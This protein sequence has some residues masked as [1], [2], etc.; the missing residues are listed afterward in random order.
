MQEIIVERPYR[1]VPPHRGDW[2][3]C[4]MQ[5]FRV[6]DRYLRKY[7]GIHSY[8]VRGIDYLKESLRQKAGIIL[9]PNHCR[10]ADPL[11]MC[12]V[13]RP[14]D[15]SPYAMASWHLFQRPLQTLAIRLCG[16]FSVNREGVDRQALET[17]ISAIAEGKRPLI[18]F[19]EGTVFRSNDVLQPLLD[20]IAFIARSA[21]K[22]RAKLNK[23]PAVILPVAIKYL[24]RG[25]VIRSITP[26][27]EE[28]E[29]RFSWHL[30]IR[31]QK[32]MLERVRHLCHAYL[33][34]KELE[35]LGEV[36]Q[37]PF[38]DRR[39]FL[40]ETLLGQVESAWSIV[41]VPDRAIIP[42]IKA[43]RLKMVPELLDAAT[44]P[45]RKEQIRHDLNCIYVAQQ[46]SSYP[47]SYLDEPVTNTRLLET[48]EQLDED[49]RDHARI[50]RPLHAILQ[51]GAPLQVDEAKPPRNTTDPLLAELDARLRQML[52]QLSQEAELLSSNT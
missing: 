2:L 20:G 3:P 36:G 33:A 24:F 17:A 40:I 32:S 4:L 42:R 12:W 48:V 1:F 26:I 19:P 15:I 30:P 46:V 5:R 6:V 27:V 8:E 13:L 21:A 50:H 28:Y 9:A 41:E 35:H 7:E 14:V 31:R 29:H 16:G 51:I 49:I 37:G 10:Y 11:A 34:T 52:E 22:R 23:S 45:A 47:E 43:L 38:A 39:D 18:L 25:D 44:V